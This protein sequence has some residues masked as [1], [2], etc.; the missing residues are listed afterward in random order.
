MRTSR[1]TAAIIA[2][3]CSLALL[4]PTTGAAAE[5]GP[6]RSATE[7]LADKRYVAA[8]DRAYIIGAADGGFPAM[9]WHIRGEMGGVWAHPIKLLD[10]YWFAVD[11]E[12]LPEAVEFTAGAGY[13]RMDYPE[14][15]GLEVSRTEFAPDDAAAAL[16]GLTFRNR[17]QRARPFRLE[18]DVR[19]DLL[20]SYPWGWSEPV[21]AAA[22]N[23]P[24]EVAYDRRSGTVTFTEPERPW[25]ALVRTSERPVQGRTGDDFWGPLSAQEQE[26]HSEFGDGAGARLRWQVNLP[27][28]QETTIWIAVSGSHTDEAEAQQAL[29][30]ALADPEGLLDGKIEGRLELLNRTRVE[31]PDGQL[32]EAFDWGKLNL[33]DLRITT[34]DLAVRD[35]DEGSAYPEPVATIDEA[36]GIGAGFPDYPWYFGTDGAYT[37]YPLLVS[38]Q[39]DTLMD[40]LR[41]LRD[42]SRAI[43]G[44]TG[45]IVHEVVTDGSVYFGSNEHPGQHQETPQFAAAVDLV[46]RWSGDRDFAEEMYDIVV[47]GMRTMTTTLDSDGDGWPEGHGMVERPGMGEE[48]LDVSAYTWRALLALARM[49]DDLGDAE[50]A[51]W[52]R[53]SAQTMAADFDDAWWMDEEQLYADSLC[54]RPEEDPEEG[55]INYCTEGDNAQLQQRH[56]INAVPAEVEIAPEERAQALL[57]TLEGPDFTGDTGLFHTGRGGGPDGEGELRVWTLPSS[58]MA[59]GEANYGRLGDD[60]ALFYSH[61]IAD[62]LD[63]EMPGALPE[64]AP[65]PEYDPF[66][67]FRDRAM[68][69]QAWSSYGTQWPVIHHFLGVRPDVPGGTLEVIPHVPDTWP[70]LSVEALQVGTGAV[71]ASARVEGDN[72]TT[73]VDETAGLALVIG[74]VVPDDVVVTSV[75]LN[76]QPA[77]YDSVATPRGQVIRVHATGDGPHTLVVQVE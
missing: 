60:Q 21:D 46:W 69:M 12:W 20:P 55:W 66:D 37:A 39:W 70:G 59:V 30:L 63:L 51:E 42:V 68:F 53:S 50:T 34:T 5:E 54:N 77:D 67:D 3:F 32:Q 43:N 29:D 27:G 24:D 58:V 61:T 44:D 25:T 72:Y 36:T 15:S 75:T 9:G 4:A 23:N 52:A 33:A 49:A 74:H 40:H 1:L 35:V 56:W 18:M 8:G 41:L 19:S 47:D 6:T 2:A 26:D 13:V 16:V 22:F 28:G 73:T 17:D 65:S 31:L 64:I 71:A 57:D 62:E 10:G 11:G 76:G 45:K 14:V 7:R 48:K 38:G